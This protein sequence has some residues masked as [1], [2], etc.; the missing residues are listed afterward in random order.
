MTNT[1]STGNP[2]DSSAPKDLFD[3]ASN[4]DEFMNSTAPSALDRFNRRRQTWAGAEYEWQQIMQSSFYEP[5]HLTYVDGTPLVVARATQLFDRGGS[6]YR[7]K[8]PATFPYTLTGIWATDL[9]N[10]VDVGDASL[11]ADLGP[12]FRQ[13]IDGSFY[14]P[15]DLDVTGV[16]DESAKVLGYLNTYKRVRLPGNSARIKLTN[17]I[18][19]SGCSLVGGG[20]TDMNRTSKVWGA[21]GTT[22][23]GTIQVT[24]SKGCVVGAMNIDAFAAGGNA[25]AGVSYSTS[26]HYIYEVN[27]RAADHGQL[28]EQNAAPANRGQGGN[29]YVRDCKHYDGPNGFVS[30]MKNVT[31]ERCFAY[32]VTVQ[33]H[34]A[35][36]DNINGATTYSRAENTQFIDCGGDGCNIGLTIYSRDAFSTTN[37]NGVAGTIGT[38]WRGTHTNVTAGFIHVGLFRPIDA[39]TTALFNDQVTIDGGQYFNAPVFGIRF[40]DAARPRVMAGHFQNCLNPIVYGEQCVD[41]YVSDE[42]SVFGSINPGILSPYIVDAG[43]AAA[44]NVDIV[45]TLLILQ[46]TTVTAVTTL[47]S[48]ARTRTLRVLIDDNVTTLAIGGLALA[49]K[50]SVIDLHWDANVGWTVMSG[51]SQL[52]DSEVPFEYALNLSLFW[53]S[54]AAFVQMTGNINLL[55]V[56]GANVP[57]GT[58]V[59]LRLASASAFNVNSWSGVTW[60]LITP[61]GAIT[62]GQNIVIQFYY[63]G[64]TFLAMAVN[65][66]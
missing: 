62:A 60:G 61:V 38:Y 44:I 51:G 64:A 6:V 28:W 36:S 13:K 7:I 26:D 25:L 30:K 20:R 3:N 9:P 2:L 11:R 23:L 65:R 17:L 10:V 24:G 49:G 8:T 56:S 18:V 59:T 54:K 52:P 4:F 40:D 55:D 33:A 5:V 41:P 12:G 34:V 22:V 1:Y 35:V 19:P 15:N 63:T 27:T 31:F 46:R 39:G 53:R 47:V 50:G 48:S 16:T 58:I 66:Y 43:T 45:K 42:V 14:Q 37:A 29:I 32:D 21:G 57:K